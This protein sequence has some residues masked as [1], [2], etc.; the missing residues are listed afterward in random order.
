MLLFTQRQLEAAA[1][2]TGCE[3][4]LSQ[5]QKNELQKNELF[6]ILDKTLSNS[7]A[8]VGKQSSIGTGGHEERVLSHQHEICIWQDSCCARG[9]A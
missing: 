2:C 9:A 7:S 4:Q 8:N 5:N 1:G 6:A 3:P